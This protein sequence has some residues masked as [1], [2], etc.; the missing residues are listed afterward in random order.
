MGLNPLDYERRVGAAPAP[1]QDDLPSLAAIERRRRRLWLVTGFFLLVASGAVTLTLTDVAVAEAVPDIPALRWGLLLLAVAFLLY[2]FDQ[3]RLL[4][5]FTRAF[6]AHDVQTAT[7]ETRILDL[8]TLTRVGRTV[9][10]VLTVGEVVE[11]V[12][13]AASELTRARNGSVMLRDDDELRVVASRGPEAAPIGA[14]VPLGE[15]LVGEVAEHRR[16]LLVTGLLEADE[17]AE[18]RME[19]RAFGSAVVA[20][21]AAHG[22]V[23][24][25]VSLERSHRDR[26]FTELDLHSIALFSE[27]ASLAISNAQRY[28]GERSTATRLTEVLELRS[29]FVAA[30]VHDLKNPITAILGFTSL[31][32]DRW[33]ALEPEQRTRSLDAIAGEG[34]RL[35]RMVDEVLYSTSVEAG[36]ELRRAP[37]TVVELL[38]PLV[39]TV[40][41]GTCAQEGVQRTIELLVPPGDEAATVRGDAQAL[42][43]VFTN[44]LDNAIK[45]SAPGRPVEVRV[46]AGGSHVEVAVTDHGDGIAAED[47]PH[48]FERFRQLPGRSRGGVG[49]GLYIARTLVTAQGGQLSVSSEVGRGSTFHVALPAAR[50]EES[51]LVSTPGPMRP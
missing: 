26:E 51:D 4:R 11:T 36:A 48:V 39:D 50:S 40:A 45:Y 31:M 46:S 15:G 18:G 38:G 32:G 8:T 28:E 21:L 43:H 30:L 19:Q 13:G 23:V 42:R 16:P 41:V 12:L 17:R 49:L 22:E 20:P 29:E 3:E 37:V 2:V 47:L 5:S 24:G 34:E 44:L 9:S 25:V 14:V 33:A 35:L 6:V 1:T 10:S 27:H 7:L